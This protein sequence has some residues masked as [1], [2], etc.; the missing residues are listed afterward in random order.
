M[1]KGFTEDPKIQQIAEAYSLDAVDFANDNFQIKLD[2][3]DKSVSQIE[4]ILEIFH[5]QLASA[6]PS[7]EQIF[8]FAKIFGS[9][10]GE[11]YRRNHGAT[12]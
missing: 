5:D 10:V 7:E 4:S 2:W 12:R 6:D 3:S 1:S 8:Q 9:Y 11:V